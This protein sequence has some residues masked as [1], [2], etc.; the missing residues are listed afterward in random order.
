M[1]QGDPLGRPYERVGVLKTAAIVPMKSLL[2]AKSRLSSVLSPEERAALALDMLHHVL[3]VIAES[4]EISD[5]AVISPDADSLGLPSGITH[6]PQIRAGLNNVLEQGKQ[7]AIEIGADRL[8]VVFADLPFLSAQDITEMVNLAG[9]ANNTV[10]LAPD[11]HKVGTNA[12]LV[13]P[14]SLARFA[15]GTHSYRIHLGTYAKAG[16]RV[17][18]YMS[19]GTSLDMDTPFDLSF[20]ERAAIPQAGAKVIET[21][22]FT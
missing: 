22:Q 8:L 17:M 2:D 13:Q 9:A 16:A 5:A 7:W 4:S 15:F 12:M 14:V 19:P 1:E 21:E 3:D 20:L 6:L 18:T 11:R 10:V